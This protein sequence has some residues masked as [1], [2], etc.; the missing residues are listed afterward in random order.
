MTAS[1]KGGV[2]ALVNDKR[3][4]TAPI[5]IYDSGSD[6]GAVSQPE[7]AD[8][9]AA[10]ALGLAASLAAA[11]L[12]PGPEAAGGERSPPNPVA[13]PAAVPPQSA[14]VDRSRFP[15]PFTIEWNLD[16]LNG[17]P[18]LY[19]VV[20]FISN[21]PAASGCGDVRAVVDPRGNEHMCE[22]DEFTQHLPGVGDCVLQQVPLKREC[23]RACQALSLSGGCS[24]LLSLAAQWR[25]LSRSTS[26]RA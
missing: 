10:T 26:H 15:P 13:A 11:E 2:A 20:R 24:T 17:K 16:P 14:P 9:A 25:G 21:V 1:S 3:S 12:S 6:D 7:P 18:L 4:A 8:A 5:E 19:P 22:P 23:R